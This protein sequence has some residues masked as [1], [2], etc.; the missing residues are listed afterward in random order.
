MDSKLNFYIYLYISKT[1]GKTQQVQ[2][3]EQFSIAIHYFQGTLFHMN[4]M[5]YE[6]IKPFY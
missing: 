6:T 3:V 5:L 4:V 1:L 2:I